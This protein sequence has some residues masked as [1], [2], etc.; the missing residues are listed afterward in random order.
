M[1]F[2]S[3]RGNSGKGLFSLYVDELGVEVL[4]A[5]VGAAAGA[6]A[7]V[8]VELSVVH[9]P[10]GAFEVQARCR[11][12]ALKQSVAFGAFQLRL[13]REVLDFFKAMATLGTAIGIQ[14]QG[15][16]PS[17]KFTP[18]AY[19]IGREANCLQMP[20]CRV[21]SSSQVLFHIKRNG[22][23]LVLPGQGE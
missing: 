8:D 3:C 7:G 6:E 22:G 2:A 20:P 12:R 10:A 13:G 16:S 21:T 4:G 18:Y 23:C 1:H 5:E 9:I 15:S 11:Q 17:G 19:C 14:R